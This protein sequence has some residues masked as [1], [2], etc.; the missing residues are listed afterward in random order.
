[1]M[2]DK[3]RGSAVLAAAALIAWAVS[4]PARADS[5]ATFEDIAFTY[6][7]ITWTWVDGAISAQDE[8]GA[9]LVR[10]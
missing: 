6:S 4:V 9:P 7:T 5:I 3:N 8:W 2:Q 10:S 1:M